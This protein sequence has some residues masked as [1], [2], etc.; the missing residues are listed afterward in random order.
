MPHVISQDCRL[1]DPLWD[2]S[3]TSSSVSS[4]STSVPPPPLPP[5][6][7]ANG[8]STESLR[9]ENACALADVLIVAAGSAGLVQGHWVKPGAVVIDV[10]FNVLS[11]EEAHVRGLLSPQNGSATADGSNSNSS[12]ST[13][14]NSSDGDKNNTTANFVCGDVRFESARTRAAVITPVPGGVG[15][16]TVAMLMR[17]TVQTFLR[18]QREQQPWRGL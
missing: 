6:G 8:D 5:P 14:S 13:K 12:R 7:I 2:T 18:R 3:Y 10:G 11:R 1:D 15:P 9:L 4:T 16:M 17:N